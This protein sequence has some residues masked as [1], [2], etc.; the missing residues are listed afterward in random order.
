MLQQSENLHFRLIGLGDDLPG[1]INELKSLLGPFHVL[2][3]KEDWTKLDHIWG[4]LDENQK[5]R[6][7]REVNELLFL[8]M[9]QIET[10]V[11]TLDESA[12]AAGKASDPATL[13][14][15]L[16]VCDRGLA[17]A[18]PREPWLALRD[19]LQEQRTGPARDGIGPPAR[20]S[21]ALRRKHS[22]ASRS[23]SATKNRLRHAFN[24]GCSAPARTGRSAPSS[25]CSRLSGS[26]GAITGISSTWPTC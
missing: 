8:W 2:T 24:G 10:S 21:A 26:T 11:H 20:N 1:A 4:L 18:E 23:T 6:L 22:T 5:K 19:L 7:R 17:F 9:V 13:G 12:A 15:A 3:S 16:N 14:Q 25:G